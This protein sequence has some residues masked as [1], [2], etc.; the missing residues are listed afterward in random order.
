MR[1]R[2]IDGIY[3]VVH[4]PPVLG[5]AVGNGDGHPGWTRKDAG[6]GPFGE[7][8]RIGGAGGFW[9]HHSGNC[10]GAGPVGSVAALTFG[11][12]GTGREHHGG[13]DERRDV[14]TRLVESFRT[15]AHSASSTLDAGRST[16]L[17]RKPSG[18]EQQ[19]PI[20]I[21][22]ADVNNELG[23]SRPVSGRTQF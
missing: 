23:D 21:A 14:S 22:A 17:I 2:A 20:T 8:G 4:G 16:T 6:D 15:G 3:S 7:L 10:R 1:R 13:E 18:F 11:R 5:P 9:R 19:L 12:T